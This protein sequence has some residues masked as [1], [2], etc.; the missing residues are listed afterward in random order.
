M[1]VTL[2]SMSFSP[3]DV[4]ALRPALIRKRPDE[5]GRRLHDKISCSL[6]N[7]TPVV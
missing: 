2:I 1:R 5:P 6:G 3:L 4:P 7:R